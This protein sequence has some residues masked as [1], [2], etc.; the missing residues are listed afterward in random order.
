MIA[1]VFEVSNSAWPKS[2]ASFIGKAA[3]PGPQGAV[4]GGP[5]DLLLFHS[6]SKAKHQGTRKKK[7]LKN[8]QGLIEDDW[9]DG[10][11]TLTA[12]EEHHIA[13]RVQYVCDGRQALDYLY[14]RGK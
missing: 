5:G 13:N 12:L 4:D 3:K 11:I 9:Q 14:K 7:E 8:I 6:Q 10:E 2:S 1:K